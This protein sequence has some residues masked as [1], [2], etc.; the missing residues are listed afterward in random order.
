MWPNSSQ[1][2]TL[3]TLEVKDVGQPHR[4]LTIHLARKHYVAPTTVYN[5]VLSN[6]ISVLHPKPIPKNSERKTTNPVY[7]KIN[8]QVPTN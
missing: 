5:N 1:L 4:G 7:L 3:P 8:P 2:R 6:S